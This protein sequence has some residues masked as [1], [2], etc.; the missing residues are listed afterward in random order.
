MN[1]FCYQCEQTAKGTGCTAGGVC[2]KS[3]ETASLQNMLVAVTKK[4][5]GYAHR[6]RQFGVTDRQAEVFIIEA[7]F[8]TVTN[9]NFDPARLEQL[10]RRAM[11]IGGSL[12]QRY[13]KQC[14]HAGKEPETVCYG[15]C[16]LA[17]TLEDM[18]E[19]GQAFG[20]DKRVE[21]LGP[22]VAG[23]Q[24]LIT[25]GLKG[26]AAYADHAQIL[27][28]EDDG[29]YASFSEILIFLDGNPTDIGE[30]AEMALK[31][32]ELNLK[33][34][35]LLDKANTDRYGHPEPTQVRVTPIA[36]KCILVSGHDLKDLDELL[37]QTVG[38]GIN[39]YTHGE[40]L[41]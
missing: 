19:M 22:D 16:C 31:T 7:L 11:K 10:L 12:K 27:G 40:M 18:V 38:K 39:V 30:L 17:G 8:S 28:V 15:D 3:P 6:L 4:L 1:M 24:E 34:M 25:Y 23:L 2:G 37:K 21:A 26:A 13:E 20:V 33:V 5:G 29:V 36:G 41:P 32:G 35:E 14:R 9:V